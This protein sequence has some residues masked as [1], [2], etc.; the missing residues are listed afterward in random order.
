[1][2]VR[3]DWNI[4]LSGRGLLDRKVVVK[5]LRDMLQGENNEIVINYSTNQISKA[6]TKLAE[7]KG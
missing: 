6:H 1:M 5:N 3:R 4:H 7:D 2:V